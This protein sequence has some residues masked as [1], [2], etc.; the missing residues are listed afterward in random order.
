MSRKKVVQPRKVQIGENKYEIKT[1]KYKA[2]SKKKGKT[3]GQI[4]YS[5]NLIEVNKDQT[6]DRTFTNPELAKMDTVIHEIL[7]GIVAEYEVGVDGRKEERWVTLLA[8]GLT[9]VLK[10]NPNLIEWIKQQALKD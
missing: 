6:G 3:F 5:K 8:N 1:R 10:K 2:W 4:T 9:D 7:H